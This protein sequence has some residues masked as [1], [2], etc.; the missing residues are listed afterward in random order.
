MIEPSDA[1]LRRWLLQQLPTEDAAPL[2]QRLLEDADFSERLHAAETDLLDDFAR[3]HLDETERAAAAHLLTATPR[4]RIR[5][6]IAFALARLTGHAPAALR[7][8]HGSASATH[9]HVGSPLRRRRAAAASL[10]AACALI[11]VVVGLNLRQG[12]TPAGKESTITLLANQQR[13]M[14]SAAIAI[15]RATATIRLQA[16]VDGA[17]TQQR[18]TLDI[19]QGGHSLFTAHAI[20][21]RV[22]GPYR[23]VEV[24]VPAT[25]LRAGEHRVRVVA[26]G[27]VPSESTWLIQTHDP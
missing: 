12:G 5:L 23:F 10:F 3:G 27:A 25:A 4:D 19:E 26:E 14:T 1:T 13:G 7:L 17:D 22:S 9:R 6:R 16:E 18:Y 21:V 20:A 8:R 11:A 24:S 15:P 2:E